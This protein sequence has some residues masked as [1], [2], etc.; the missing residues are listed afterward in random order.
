LHESVDLSANAFGAPVD[1]PV[2]ILRKLGI[3]AADWLWLGLS[4]L[5]LSQQAR[6][7]LA[8]DIIERT[9]LGKAQTVSIDQ[10]I[11]LIVSHLIHQL[12]PVS[13]AKP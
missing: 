8:L 10:R 13:Q 7:F 9:K 5:Q 6:G 1:N 4:R 11:V 3:G 2:H 12:V